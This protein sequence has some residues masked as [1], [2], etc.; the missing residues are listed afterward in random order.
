MDEL[1]IFLSPIYFILKTN[2]IKFGL[3]CDNDKIL[4]Y[5]LEYQI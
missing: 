5:V 4:F 1:R 2:Y 3:D